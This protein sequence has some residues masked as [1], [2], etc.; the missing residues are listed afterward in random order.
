MGNSNSELETLILVTLTLTK[1][2]YFLP[3]QI[4]TLNG[5]KYIRRDFEKNKFLKSYH[6]LKQDFIDDNIL[7]PLNIDLSAIKY[8]IKL[9][10]FSENNFLIF[11]SKLPAFGKN[12]NVNKSSNTKL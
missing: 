4:V 8:Q 10:L 12:K 1:I 3:F 5:K 7:N 11:D 6:H 2:V 9:N